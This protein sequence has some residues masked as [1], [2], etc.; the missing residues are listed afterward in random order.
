[1]GSY[2]ID[3]TEFTIFECGFESNSAK[4]TYSLQFFTLA[5]S[6]IAFDFEIFLL[7]P[8]LCLVPIVFTKV[9]STMS[10]YPGVFSLKITRPV[11]RYLVI[12]TVVFLL[13]SFKAMFSSNAPISMFLVA[14]FHL[15]VFYTRDI[16]LVLL[17]A[18]L[19]LC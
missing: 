9:L 4:V 11:N 3:S 15:V 14:F 7:L 6:F 17:V 8:F 12:L 10:N 19:I 16:L 5:L 2:N 1:M 18:D 13:L